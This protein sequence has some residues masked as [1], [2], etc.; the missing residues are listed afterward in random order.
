MPIQTDIVVDNYSLGLHVYKNLE[1]RYSPADMIT[2][3]RAID[4]TATIQRLVE[5]WAMPD[6]SDTSLEDYLMK[7]ESMESKY[8]LYVRN[9]PF[10]LVAQRM[11]QMQIS[12]LS[13]DH[14]DCFNTKA[15]QPSVE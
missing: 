14:Q 3:K 12:R 15:S 6:A 8:A 11:L 2:G 7:I 1:A 4:A 5:L 9:W 10:F 13:E